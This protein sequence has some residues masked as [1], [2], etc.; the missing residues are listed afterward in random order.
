MG[1]LDLKCTGI[2]PKMLGANITYFHTLYIKTSHDRSMQSTLFQ[3]HLNTCTEKIPE[4][5][6]LN[7]GLTNSC[8][9]TWN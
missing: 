1:G 9:K 8:Y 3:A 7:Y 5:L 4:W 6:S 2:V